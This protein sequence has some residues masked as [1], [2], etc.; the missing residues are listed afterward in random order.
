VGVSFTIQLLFQLAKAWL[1]LHHPTSQRDSENH[2]GKKK[3][4]KTKKNHKKT[5]K[6]QKKPKKTKKKTKK[7]QKKKNQNK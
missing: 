4:E 2:R 3:P 5:K 1:L 7:N 6:N